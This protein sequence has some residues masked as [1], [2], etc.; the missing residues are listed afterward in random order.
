[1]RASCLVYESDENEVGP[2]TEMPAVV[3]SCRAAIASGRDASG[4][5]I[6]FLVDHQM[7]PRAGVRLGT[8]QGW[9]LQGCCYDLEADAAAF[10]AAVVAA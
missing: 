8:A 4:I 5:I 6:W 2:F 3:E 7:H 10:M 1:M 9:C